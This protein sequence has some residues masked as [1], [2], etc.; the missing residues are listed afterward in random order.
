MAREMVR[1][2]L[3]FTPAA[4]AWAV[5]TTDEPPADS[6]NEADY[7]GTE[8][9]VG[10]ALVEEQMSI[11]DAIVSEESDGPTRSVIGMVAGKRDPRLNYAD[12]GCDWDGIF[13]GYAHTA[14]PDLAEWKPE[15]DSARREYAKKFQ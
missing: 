7:W 8:P 2:I 14:S 6:N 1:K 12:E 13:V 5:Y 15:I 3:S 11:G 10:W 4:N 9:L